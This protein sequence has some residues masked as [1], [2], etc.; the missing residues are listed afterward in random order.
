[1]GSRFDPLDMALGVLKTETSTPVVVAP[2]RPARS[3]IIPSNPRNNAI[4]QAQQS[5]PEPKPPAVQLPKRQ[6]N[7]TVSSEAADRLRQAAVDLGGQYSLGDIVE[8]LISAGLGTVTAELART[9]KQI[10]L[11]SGRKLW[12]QR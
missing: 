9:D 6:L 11:R 4:Q 3:K 8:R 10:R 1:M 5:A 12:A 7:V 2:E